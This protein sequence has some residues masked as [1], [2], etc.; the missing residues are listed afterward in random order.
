MNSPITITLLHNFYYLGIP[1]SYNNKCSCLQ[2]HIAD[3]GCKA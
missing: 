1:F 3:Q 2:K